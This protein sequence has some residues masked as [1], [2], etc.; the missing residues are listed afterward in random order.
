MLLSICSQYWATMS[1]NTF[2]L[3]GQYDNN[4]DG[5]VD[6]DN[7]TDDDQNDFTD[8]LEL[9]QYDSKTRTIDILN[10]NNR[11]QNSSSQGDLAGS[12]SSFATANASATI[13]S[14]T[15]ASATLAS[16]TLASADSSTEEDDE[17]SVF[18]S[19]DN[20]VNRKNKRKYKLSSYTGTSNTNIPPRSIESMKI[21]MENF[22]EVK[23]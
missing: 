18:I 20:K 19:E 15:I 21:S 1:N 12:L 2:T 6:V 22:Y 17:T 5:I 14:A 9:D 16:A 3:L 23:N 4:N 8:I 7:D 13:A 10:K 11:R